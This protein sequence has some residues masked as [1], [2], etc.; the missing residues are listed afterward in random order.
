M[1]LL[2]GEGPGR[3]RVRRAGWDEEADVSDVRE[4]GEV[5]GGADPGGGP[6]GRGGGGAGAG[7][8]GGG[9]AVARPVRLGIGRAGKLC[10]Y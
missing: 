8:G 7:G 2:H 6:G 10:T 3:P 4:D 5:H 1:T 9:W